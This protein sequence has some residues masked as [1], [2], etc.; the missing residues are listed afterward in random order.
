M[1]RAL[2]CSTARNLR[3]VCSSK[4]GA[5]GLGLVLKTDAHT[6]SD[7]SIHT[8]HYRKEALGVYF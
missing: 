5:D 1:L 6:H 2:G 7:T 8:L 4:Q 3:T